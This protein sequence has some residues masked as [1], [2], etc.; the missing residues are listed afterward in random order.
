M[1]KKIIVNRQPEMCKVFINTTQ[2]YTTGISK[3]EI[4]NLRE[5]L[6]LQFKRL[7]TQNDAA[8]SLYKFLV[9]YQQ[10]FAGEEEMKFDRMFFDEI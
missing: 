7:S 8:S 3:A 4:N 5:P 2:N 1:L 10:H 6:Q 9:A